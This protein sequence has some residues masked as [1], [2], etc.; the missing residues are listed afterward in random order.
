MSENVRRRL[1]WIDA[2]ASID[3]LSRR[4]M[5]AR[6][7]DQ[8]TGRQGRLSETL[9]GSPPGSEGICR[10]RIGLPPNPIASMRAAIPLRWRNARDDGSGLSYN[11]R[12]R[13]FQ[14][15]DTTRPVQ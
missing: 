2:V 11:W 13:N 14:Q 9:L 8:T 5:S 12:C 10:R 3:P 1:A 7:I 4:S 15:I 6:L